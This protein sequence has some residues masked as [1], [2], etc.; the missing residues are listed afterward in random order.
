M[1]S[2][3]LSSDAH[4][5][6]VIRCWSDFAVADGETGADVRPRGRKARALLA[7]LA[8]HPGKPISRDRLCG[9]LWGDRAD[10]QARASLRQTLFELR[11]FSKGDR[12]LIEAG[13]ETIMIAAEAVETDINQLRGLFDSGDFETLLA[14]L[15]QADD[16]LFANLDGLDPAFDDWLRIERVRHRDEL[17][18]LIG[19]A[20]ASAIAAGK[21][22]LG[23]LLHGRLVEFAGA[24]REPALPIET[25]L[26]DRLPSVPL[27]GAAGQAPGRGMITPVL[28]FAA[29]LSVAVFSPWWMPRPASRSE[30]LH[31]E[32]YGLYAS[33]REMVRKRNSEIKPAIEMLRRAVA[34]DPEFAPAWAELAVATGIGA[35][36]QRLLEAEHYARRALAINPDL[37]EAHAALGMI[38][39]FHG[40]EAARHLKR[41][42]E[43][44]PNDA[45]TQFWVSNYYANNL[46]FGKRLAALRRAVAIDP[47]WPR[48]VNE[49]ALAAWGMGHREE[50]AGYVQRIMKADPATA[51]DCDYRL[52]LASG[53]YA[54]IVEKI[55]RA[56][57]QNGTPVQA[58][59][60]LGFVLLILGYT[61]PA[62]LLLHLP[63][64]Q[65]DIANGGPIPAGALR[66]VEAGAATGA[67]DASFL[68]LT[69]QRLLFEGQPTAIVAR[70]GDKGGVLPSL[71]SKEAS[72]SNVVEYGPDVALALRA[73]G[74]TKEAKVLL[75]R[76]EALVRKAFATGPVS[77]EFLVQ[78]AKLRAAQGRNDEALNLLKKAGD[79]GWEYAPFAP[80]PDI[81]RIYAF[82]NLRGDPL[83]EAIRKAG[84]DHI[85][86]ERQAVGPVPV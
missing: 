23:R 36:S 35:D 30:A 78:A 15:P 5:R 79:R 31:Q 33:A 56:R 60:K 47:Y 49:A 81:A 44:D 77:G 58:D 37:A 24:D 66:Q 85:D 62:R 69:I 9:L 59:M 32:A 55:A 73:V 2:R 46:D 83:F 21:S 10:E 52:D 64:F 29:A 40:P 20:S 39:G 53:S 25:L 28:L 54:A 50:A 61:E 8:L 38:V 75:D 22:R 4:R 51:F 1:A 84:L 63:Q 67:I 7:Y 43:L 11:P 71:V 6:T 82:R 19:D 68:D 80:R 13:R 76:A 42:V 12:P 3:L 74:R 27:E 34:I 41:A 14:A 70:L 72:P 45:Q 86:R 18:T 17:V 48:A 26:I 16:V 57:R 65:W